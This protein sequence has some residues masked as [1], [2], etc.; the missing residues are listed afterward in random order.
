MPL[1]SL[2][3]ILADADRESY[4]VPAFNC[5]NA[6]TVDAV[7]LAAEAA[8][9][10]VIVQVYNRLFHSK[11]AANVAACLREAAAGSKL[12]IALH[13]DH[14][15]GEMEV[16]R[17][18]RLGYTSV[19]IDGSELPFQANVEK[20]A[21]V[22][23]LAGQ[24]G[25]SVEAELGHVGRADQ[26]MDQSTFT[27]PE[28]AAE[29]VA[30]TKV[31]ALAVMV[32]SAHGTY[33]TEPKLDIARIA[34]IKAKTGLPLVLHGGSGIPDVEIRAAVAAGIRKINVATDVCQSFY[35]AFRGLPADDP[36]Y[37]KPLDLFMK[38]VKDRMVAFMADRIEVFGSG[39]RA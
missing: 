9:S 3:E 12:P 15:A 26:E 11:D 21:A 39:G 6:E 1:V 13:L 30:L 7:L 8:R 19:M 32:G 37:A 23:R 17:A 22:T 29:F 28:E 2:V 25:V 14:G 36:A 16:L 38:T 20:T 33:R 34:A 5:Y 35:S 24:V 18:L 27:D 4:A 10:P 31:D